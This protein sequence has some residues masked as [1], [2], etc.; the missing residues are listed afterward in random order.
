MSDDVVV[1]ELDQPVDEALLRG[2]EPAEGDPAPADDAPAAEPQDEPAAEPEGEPEGERR[3]EFIPKARFNEV[4]EE[5][6]QLREELERLRAAQQPP[7]EPELVVDIKALRREA[8]NALL[9][10]DQDRHDELQDQIDNELLRQAEARAEEKLIQRQEATTFKAKAAEL[11]E[12]YPVLNP[13]TGDP[14]AIA[15]VIELRDA[16]IAKGMNMT[17]ALETA[18]QKIAPRFGQPTAA[19]PAADTRQAAAVKRGATDSNR[20]PPQGGGVGNR[21][22][23]PQANDEPSQSEWENMT[24]AQR[25]KALEAAGA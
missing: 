23:P 21:A 17:V 22:Q 19:A 2:D 6:K 20:I 8:T 15:L 3:D 25:Q 24:P 16:Y 13:E 4:N 14:E 12:R 11:T 18:V 9:E 5:R 10:G 7:A 1:D